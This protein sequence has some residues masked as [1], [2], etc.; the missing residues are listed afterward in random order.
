MDQSRKAARRP[1]RWVAFGA[2]ILVALGAGWWAAYATL[3]P[4]A[5]TAAPDGKIVATVTESTVGQSL[6]LNV[7][8]SQP[9]SLVASNL[10]PGVVTA[11]NP[12]PLNPGD[13][14]YSVAG[15]PVRVVQGAIPFYRDLKEQLSGDDVRQLQAALVSLDHLASASIDGKYGPATSKAVRSWQKATGQEVTGV[16]PLGTL[17]A[18]PALPAAVHFDD[19][20]RVGAVLAGSE[21]AVMAR[22]TPPS[23]SLVVSADQAAAIP[24]DAVVNVTFQAATWPAVIAGTRRDESGTVA[25][26]LSAPDGSI[27]CAADCATLPSDETL[28]LLAQVQLVPDASGPSVPVA[29]IRTDPNG[30]TYVYS[31]NARE[32]PVEVIASGNGLA[33]V[34]GVEIGDQILVAGMPPSAPPTPTA[35]HDGDG[36]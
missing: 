29:A 10:L 34:S 21:P 36:N 18:V 3:V 32:V 5:V 12:A 1:S 33:V 7:T 11:L 30:K 16:V 4:T 15:Q 35:T 23:F 9:F 14:A 6:T 13:A 17:I 19:A 28:S 24:A 2:S 20:I 26:D 27:V 8:V 25:L 22:S 31:E